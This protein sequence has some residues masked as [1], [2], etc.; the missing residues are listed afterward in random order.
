M[1]LSASA[2]VAI[3]WWIKAINW[4][5]P[6]GQYLL[7]TSW[8]PWN[9]GKLR[10]WCLGYYW[11]GGA[12]PNLCPVGQSQASSGQISWNSWPVGQVQPSVGQSSW[13]LWPAGQFQPLTGQTIWNPCPAGYAQPFTGQASWNDWGPGTSSTA[14]SASCTPWSINYYNALSNKEVCTPWPDGY[15]TLST[16]STFWIPIWGDGK[17]KIGEEWDDGDTQNGDGC[18]SIWNVETGYKCKYH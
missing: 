3:I 1:R 12:F 4:Q 7:S 5:W 18:S 15:K 17:R 14:G 6:A 8:S 10:A 13:N 9:A 16:G 2:L 11:L